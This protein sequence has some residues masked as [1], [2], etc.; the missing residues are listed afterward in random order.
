MDRVWLDGPK[1][2]ESLP[3]LSFWERFKVMYLMKALKV[4][5]EQR[6]GFLKP[7]PFYIFYCWYCDN[8]SY[9][10]PHGYKNYFTCHHP[11]CQMHT[12]KLELVDRN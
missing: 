1:L 5:E 4:N 9:D 12:Y 2:K 10:Y 7:L 6:E 3:T 8:F 11:E